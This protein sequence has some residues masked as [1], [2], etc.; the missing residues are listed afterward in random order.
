[1]AGAGE[2]RGVIRSAGVPVHRTGTLKSQDWAPAGYGAGLDWTIMDGFCLLQVEQRWPVSNR[3][4]LT[5]N[6]ST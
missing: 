2:W 3:S 4:L 5:P 6:I 1:M